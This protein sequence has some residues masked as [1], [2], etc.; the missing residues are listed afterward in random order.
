MASRQTIKIP[1]IDKRGR[2]PKPIEYI[3]NDTGCWVCVSHALSH[4]YPVLRH[5]KNLVMSRYIYERYNGKIPD[6]LIVRHTCDN[7]MCINPVHLIVG[8]KL[9]NTKDM[10]ERGRHDPCRGERHGGVK[11]TE[12]Q[13][14]EIFEK[15]Q[16]GCSQVS[17]ANMY[18]VSRRNIRSILNKTI[19]K[20]IEV[21]I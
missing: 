20:H 16:S 17:L 3:T 18:N 10:L 19:W 11:L 1:R 8:T 9:E 15:R 13:V 14:I 7:P 4:G 12:E 21:G 6:T 2:E 5:G